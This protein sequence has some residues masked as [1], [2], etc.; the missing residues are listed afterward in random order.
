MLTPQD[1][2][3]KKFEKATFGGYDMSLVDD[4][5]EQV[6][7]DY[8]ALYK[9]NAILKNK[10]KVLVE[11]VEEYRATE[12]SMRMA[13]LTAQK[14]ASE[15]TDEAKTKAAAILAEA[16][17]QAARRSAELK[18]KTV[19]E[20]KRLEAAKRHTSAFSTRIL[21]LI[22]EEKLFLER[23]EELVIPG[24][25]TV[26]EPTPA[27]P[28][29][30]LIAPAAPPAAPPTPKDLSL[31]ESS[32]G[33]YL[34]REVSRIAVVSPKEDV[35]RVTV[36]PKED[37]TITVKVPRDP[38]DEESGSAEDMD[39][40]KMFD[41]DHLEEPPTPPAPPQD[42][43]AEEKIEIARSISTALGD[44]EEID[45]DV[46]AFYDDEGEPTTKRPKFEFDNLQFG[47]NFHDEDE[48]ER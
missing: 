5:L 28:A 35:S 38:F 40:L 36:S 14:M 44:T 22:A 42:V 9:E 15:I 13:L 48:D 24:S 7:E 31:E 6:Y 12:D 39:F 20:E 1:I 2:Q 43:R 33:E 8:G 3:D 47:T 29:A 27:P 32:V 34:A 10:L 26:P 45:I 17:V 18:G 41:Q 21:D 25:D 37:V 46:G 19:E 23:L 30:E 11:K 4:F 16:D